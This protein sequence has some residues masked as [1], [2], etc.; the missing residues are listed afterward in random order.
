MCYENCPRGVGAR[1]ECTE[2]GQEGRHEERPWGGF[3]D[4][5]HVRHTSLRGQLPHRG[6]KEQAVSSVTVPAGHLWDIPFD[7]LDTSLCS[8]ARLGISSLVSS[9]LAVGPL[10][11]QA[12]LWALRLQAR[13]QSGVGTHSWVPI[14][15]QASPSCHGSWKCLLFGAKL[16]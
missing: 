2:R 5:C 10:A 4:L 6:Q 16:C 9:C 13:T 12:H 3:V 11:P 1:R 8:R 15:G 7:S 14:P